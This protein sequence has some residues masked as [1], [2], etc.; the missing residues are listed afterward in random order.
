MVLAEAEEDRVVEDAALGRGDEDVLALV[1]GAFVQVA[2]DE[3]VRERESV[4][5]SD[6]DLPLDADV[7]QRDAVQELPV[8][9]YRVPVVARVVHVVVEAVHLDAVLARRVE[10]RRL[11]NARVEEHFRVLVDRAQRSSLL[12]GS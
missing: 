5:T 3:H 6:L 4:G 1:D 9:L 10:V 7:P 11:A 2:R 12:E 8:L